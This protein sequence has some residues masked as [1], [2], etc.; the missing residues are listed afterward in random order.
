MLVRIAPPVPVDANTSR[1]LVVGNR[2]EDY[3]GEDSLRGATRP[4]DDG[5]R[6]GAAV[7]RR[8]GSHLRREFEFAI[9]T[10][11]VTSG[12]L[13]PSSLNATLKIGSEG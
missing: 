7:G 3:R 2:L 5:F 9:G 8:F 11:K 13:P 10:T 6:V 12:R 1:A 4:F